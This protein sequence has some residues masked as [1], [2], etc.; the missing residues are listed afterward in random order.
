MLERESFLKSR[1]SRLSR[2][3]FFLDRLLRRKCAS[4]KVSSNRSLDKM[5]GFGP[6]STCETTFAVLRKQAIASSNVSHCWLPSRGSCRTEVACRARPILPFSR[7]QTSAANQTHLDCSRASG[8][9]ASV[10][11]LRAGAAHIFDLCPATRDRSVL[12]FACLRQPLWRATAI[13]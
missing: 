8:S 13:S 10:R 12:A 6:S 9:C 2:S 7:I 11:L 3:N 5:I 1:V 4:S